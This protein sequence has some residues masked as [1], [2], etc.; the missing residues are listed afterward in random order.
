MAFGCDEHALV[1]YG[2]KLLGGE[3]AA[4]VRRH[5]EDCPSCVAYLS[6]FA[7][8]DADGFGALAKA[9]AAAVDE[10]LKQPAE[11][12]RR[13]FETNPE[14]FANPAAV[15]ALIQECEVAFDRDAARADVLSSILTESA[16]A[17]PPTFASRTL[18]ALAWTRRATA[19]HRRGRLPDALAAVSAAV[20]RA[21]HIPA[22]DYERALIAFTAADILRELGRTEEA[23]RGI[24]EAAEVFARYNDARRHASA[25]EMEAAVLFSSGEYARAGEIFQ[26]LLDAAPADPVVRGRL[27][28]NAAHCLTRI[29]EHARALPLFAAAEEFFMGAGYATHVARIAWGKARAM[30]ATGEEEAVDALRGV[31]NRFS[32]LEATSEWVRVGIELVE[33]LLPTGAFAEVRAICTAVHERAIESGLQLQEMEAVSYLR[34]A[35]ISERLTVDGALHVRRF[36]ETLP[37]TPNAEFHIPASLG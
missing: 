8:G 12:W 30:R 35:A 31:F 13:L 14:R 15:Q 9:G 27:A 20:A 18:Q 2:L 19:L 3:E 26:T 28:A 1:R 36:I 23:L 10:M 21:N 7:P 32:E 25:R 37:S 24:R 6:T 22:A 17:L 4:E 16:D 11:E 5:L 33:W 29:G 34:D